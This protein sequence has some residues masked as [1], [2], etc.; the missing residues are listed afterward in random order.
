MRIRNNRNNNLKPPLQLG[1][2]HLAL[3]ALLGGCSADDTLPDL[4]ETDAIL[5]PAFHVGSVRTRSIANGT[6]ASGTGGT[7]NSVR[8][9]VTKSKTDASGEDGHSPYPGVT[10]TA[11][12]SLSTYTLSSEGWTGSPEVR[13]SNLEARI[14]AFSPSDATLTASNNSTAHTIPITL[15]TTQ[16]FNGGNTWESSA[17]DYMY[18]SSAQ[19][20]GSLDAITANNANPAASGGSTISYQPSIYM[21]HALSQIVFTL[22]TESGRTVTESDYVRKIELKSGSSTAFATAGTMSVADGGITASASASSFTFTPTDASSPSTGTTAQKCGDSGTA[23][24]V[25]YG[26]VAPRTVAAGNSNTLTLTVTLNARDS[27]P[28]DTRRVLT[29]SLPDTQSWEKG[30]KYVYKLTLSNRAISVGGT[31][32]K[33]WT[34]G[35]SGGSSDSMSPEGFNNN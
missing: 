30:H 3:A 33:A 1:W 20:V 26:L 11:G 18:G 16:T 2:L 5:R 13:L 24:V 29:V 28:A 34:D 23:A 14:F 32:I 10:S 25:A 19:T 27:D 21:Q 31:D 8:I 35:S 22:V 15:S 4:P 12:D 17:T 7:I 6:N 9:F